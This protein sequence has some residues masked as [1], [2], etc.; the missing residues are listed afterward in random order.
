MRRTIAWA[1]SLLVVAIAARAGAQDRVV[2][3]YRIDA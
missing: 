2:A 1:L 3:T